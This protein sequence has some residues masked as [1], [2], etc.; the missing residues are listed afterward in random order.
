MSYSTYLLLTVATLTAPSSP[1]EKHATAF[2]SDLH[3][4]LGHGKQRLLDLAVK[5]LKQKLSPTAALHY[6][7]DIQEALRELGREFVQATYNQIDPGD[8]NTLPK[9]VTFEADLFTRL[10][11]KTPQNAW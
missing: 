3:D 11:T 9:Y 10:N 4:I 8:V 7:Q 6:E 2:D 5:F 1:K